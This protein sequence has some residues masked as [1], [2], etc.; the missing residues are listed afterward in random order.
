MK[1]IKFKEIL[2]NL[3]DCNIDQFRKIQE[4]VNLI[5][6][7]NSLA[8]KLEP[9]IDELVCPYCKDKHFQKWGK[10]NDLQR[11]RCKSCLKTFNGLTGTPLAKLKIKDIWLDYAEC[12]K[13]SLSIR[14]AA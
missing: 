11:Y 6:S 7:Q 14:A 8:I 1:K 5:E 9:S 13:G 3:D 4:K 10:R 2:E 12:L